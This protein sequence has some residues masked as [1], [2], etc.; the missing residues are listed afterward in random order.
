MLQIPAGRLQRTL[1]RQKR[2]TPS[3]S[4][5]SNHQGREFLYDVA[6]KFY[7]NAA[8]QPNPL[9]RES[10]NYDENVAYRHPWPKCVLLRQ[11]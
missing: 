1:V 9:V 11:D 3:G 10:V 8:D 4:K 6:G 7:K 2:S 5:S